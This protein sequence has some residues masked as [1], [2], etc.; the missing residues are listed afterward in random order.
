MKSALTQATACLALSLSAGTVAAAPINIDFSGGQASDPVPGFTWQGFDF[1]LDNQPNENP[2]AAHRVSGAGSGELDFSLEQPGQVTYKAEIPE[3]QQFSGGQ[4]FNIGTRYGADLAEPTSG[5]SFIQP[6]LRNLDVGNPNTAASL[7]SGSDGGNP[8]SP[9]TGV[10]LRQSDQGS[11][12]FDNN[13]FVDNVDFGSESLYEVILGPEGSTDASVTIDGESADLSL[14][15][16][17]GDSDPF[18]FTELLLQVGSFQS[19]DDFN[20]QFGE[21]G[22]EFTFTSASVEPSQVPAPA[23]LPLMLTALGGLFWITHRKRRFSA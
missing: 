10:Q 21:R 7:L 17:P 19:E 20:S 3:S 6:F 22:Q 12:G 9:F 4:S 1:E 15:L 5:F 11:G 2:T 8:N 23:T 14:D 18:A 13:A 16:T